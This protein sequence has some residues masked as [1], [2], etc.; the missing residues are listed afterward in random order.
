MKAKSRLSALAMIDDTPG[1]F[2]WWV[3]PQGTEEANLLE[4]TM[5]IWESSH[6]VMRRGNIRVKVN[7]TTKAKT[8]AFCGAGLKVGGVGGV[9]GA[10][11]Q[12]GEMT[13]LIILAHTGQDSCF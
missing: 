8:L 1:D 4:R 5:Q 12:S 11:N 13:G 10:W 6:P 9:S 3:L 2:I 7:V